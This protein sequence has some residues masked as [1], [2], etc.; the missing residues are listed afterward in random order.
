[1]SYP[2]SGTSPYTDLSPIDEMAGLPS[3]TDGAESVHHVSSTADSSQQHSVS[4]SEHSPHH[5]FIS[6]QFE[7]QP[8]ENM[9]KSNFFNFVI[10]VYDS[11]NHPVE[12]HKAVFK[13]FY[14]TTANGQEYRNGL[15]Y[16]LT[17]MFSDGT[18]KEEDLYIRLIDSATKQIVPYEGTCKNPDFRRVLLTHELICSRCL[19][20]RS[21]GNKND[22]PS[23]PII[24]DRYRLKFFVKCNQN[25]LKNAGNPK[26]SRRRFQVALYSSLCLGGTPIASSDAIFVHNNSKHGRRTPAYGRETAVV[27]DGK[28]YIIAV[29]PPEGWITGGTKVC[30]VGMNFYEGVE[31]VFGT[32]PASSEFLSPHAIAVRAPQSP[33]PGEVDITLVYKGS[34]F[35]INNP[36]KFV[37]ITP[38]E[39]TF[40]HNFAR[41]ERLLRIHEDSDNIP[42]EILLR[43]AADSLEAFYTYP[44][45]QGGTGPLNHIGPAIYATTNYPRSPALFTP[46]ILTPQGFTTA[47]AKWN[48]GF[49]TGALISPT[50]AGG[51]NH[52]PGEA[53]RKIQG[54][55][56][57]GSASSTVSRS[58]SDEM[59]QVHVQGQDQQQGTAVDHDTNSAAF[60]TFPP[61]QDALA[62][63]EIKHEFQNP[64]D[65]HKPKP[66]NPGPH[67][68]PV[69]PFVQVAPMHAQGPPYS[70]YSMAAPYSV[71]HSHFMNSQG[72]SGNRNNN[73]SNVTLATYA[74]F[75]NH[76]MAVNPVFIPPSPGFF[77]AP[78]ASPGPLPTTPT[79]PGGSSV[80]NFGSPP[81]VSP[82]KSFKPM[83]VTPTKG[84]L[85]QAAHNT[86]MESTTS[87]QGT[88]IANYPMFAALP[89]PNI[90]GTFMFP[91]TTPTSQHN[92]MAVHH[93]PAS[94]N[95]TTASSVAVN[96]VQSAS[97]EPPAA[98]RSRQHED[99]SPEVTD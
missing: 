1:M 43:R 93:I 59:L 35:C 39:N 85:L 16:K 8:P 91:P 23:D 83:T 51:Y 66:I 68:Y 48:S 38:D 72:D 21:C 52:L 78:T 99:S 69:M 4:T 58:S 63:G 80:F 17:V 47:T 95:N 33:R 67:L 46:A 40:D 9:R 88:G 96:E 26:D 44:R 14:D 36:G 73:N 81:L 18:Q 60:F 24:I 37:Y 98:K 55:E 77:M 11:T 57:E 13:D 2:E 87:M 34:Q 7:K 53:I 62:H 22:T 92:T 25:C 6:A 82:G 49:A 28:P 15:I 94:S 30:I 3:P 97:M 74:N 64:S 12:V 61:M 29:H 89:S 76:M 56:A 50:K 84:G 31:V 5:Q 32:L 90:P 86:S 71:E 79:G 10:S 41:I 70:S 45:T 19:E 42:K 20:H 27:G 54:L 75:G 65:I